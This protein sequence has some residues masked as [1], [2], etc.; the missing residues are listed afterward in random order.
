MLV[1]SAVKRFPFTISTSTAS[2]GKRNSTNL[3]PEEY[4]EAPGLCFIEWADRVAAALPVPRWELRLS[5]R[6]EDCREISWREIVFANA[7]AE[8]HVQ[9]CCAP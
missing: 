3:G 2:A 7:L 5:H 9:D 1:N 4:F 6:G 8:P